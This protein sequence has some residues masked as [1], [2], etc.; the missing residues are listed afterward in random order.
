MLA[1]DQIKNTPNLWAGQVPDSW[2]QAESQGFREPTIIVVSWPIGLN[3][4]EDIDSLDN[5]NSHYYIFSLNMFQN[6]GL[7]APQ[8]IGPSVLWGGTELC[9]L[10]QVFL[11]PATAISLFIH[12]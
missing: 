4:K 2:V 9:Y 11:R 8:E 1:M 5:Q 3:M 10:L 7:W 12:P 6:H